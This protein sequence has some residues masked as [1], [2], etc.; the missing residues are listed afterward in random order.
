VVTGSLTALG[1]VR[2]RGLA[3]AL[4]AV[5]LVPGGCRFARVFIALIALALLLM[6]G[7][8]ALA[9]D[10]GLPAGGLLQDGVKIDPNNPMLLQADELVAE[11]QGSKVVAKGNVEIYYNNYTLLA[12]RVVYDR[13]SNTLTAEGHVRIK[14]PD[15]AVINAE[16]I[17][18]T[19]DFRDGFIGSLQ[20]VTKEDI[21]IAA[22][23]ATR[24]EGETTVFENGV[25]TPCKPC[26]GRPEA[27]PF[28][29]IRA[30]RITHVASEQN[31]YFE[32]AY[33][34]FFGVPVVYLPYFYAP[35]PT[36]KRRSGFLIPTF[37]YSGELGY[38][39]ETPYF[40]NIAPNLDVT[41]SPFTFYPTRKEDAAR[42]QAELQPGVLWKG[43]LR[44][45]LSNGTYT[46]E[47]A[48][49]DQQV[50]MEH[51]D[52]GSLTDQ[53]RDA[54]LR[55][56][57]RGS[58]STQGLFNLGS[59]WRLGWDATVESD[60]T[61]R[62][63]YK[64]DNILRSDRVS[65]VYLEGIS[66][67]N[68]LGAYVYSFGG[69]LSSDT[70]Q[71]ESWAHPSADYHYIVGAPVVGGELSFDANVL[72]LSREDG[73][74]TNR[75]I[76]QVNWRSQLI[77]SIGQVF[78]PFL[79]ARGDAYYVS[80]VDEPNRDDSIMRGNAVAGLMYQYPFVARSAGATHIIEPVGQVIVRPESVE[81][82]EIP[83]ED[84]RSLIFDDTLLFDIDK[85]SG[86]DLIET[87]TRA[88]VGLQYTLQFDNG[89]SVRAV[90]GQ[91]FQISEENPFE[92][93]GISTG[94]ETP[95]SDYVTGVYINANSNLRFTAQARFDEDTFALRRQ[96]LSAAFIAGPLKGTLGYAL[97]RTFELG[98]AD[99]DP[100]T[101]T[102]AEGNGQEL[103]GSFN[104][105]LTENW[106]AFTTFRYDIDGNNRIS[107]SLGLAYSDE[108]YALS[109]TYKETF[110]RDRDLLEDQSVFV[111]F[112]LKTLGGTEFKADSLT[113]LVADDDK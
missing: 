101:P 106:S 25:Y 47:M 75:A 55:D 45:R 80:N 12:D 58:I 67:R 95:Q 37:G 48:G 41:I 9:Q 97:S 77:D 96:D 70:P 27:P 1:A 98:S 90:A 5:A 32:N 52:E 22:S 86:Y 99:N 63:Y 35:D 39:T 68:Y 72:A 59:W 82:G 112:E 51:V 111:R 108:C 10:Q 64:L 60:D 34:D 46:I 14:E 26:E 15:G 6:P 56:E 78:T 89:A 11:D 2:N 79:Q 44:H 93:L 3:A 33:L 66:D 50:S 113:N 103:L 43:T 87:G 57:F 13:S 42:T 94:L 36:V 100:V 18:L 105:A 81:R 38:N 7:P 65:K 17:T 102:L 83:N 30:D 19:D 49:I 91:S 61:F 109:V 110:V 69:L 40:W 4:S 73:T 76:A 107:D 92:G 20:I 71:S 16:R 53:Q 21:R 54:L 62:R 104:L 85:F 24:K 28:W 88:N 29:R 84:A 23:S 31:I 74:D 8:A